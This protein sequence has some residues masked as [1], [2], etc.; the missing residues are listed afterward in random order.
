MKLDRI[1]VN[2]KRM[3]GQPCIRNLRITVRQL[4]ELLAIYS[5]SIHF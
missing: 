4:I 5:I 1:I 3:N 2:P